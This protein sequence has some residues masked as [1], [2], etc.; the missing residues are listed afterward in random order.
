M[1]F[2]ATSSFATSAASMLI[3]VAS[4]RN[5]NQRRQIYFALIPL[6]FSIH[7]FIEGILWLSLTEDYSMQFTR[8]S[9]YL[10]TLI[11]LI[12]WPVWIPL[13]IL[14]MEENQIRQKWL[15]MNLYLGILMSTFLLIQT[16]LNKISAEIIENHIQYNFYFSYDWIEKW[17]V[18]YLIP[19]VLSHFYSTNRYVHMLGILVLG[20]FILTKLFYP[21][22]VF[23]VWCFFAALISGFVLFITSSW[24]PKTILT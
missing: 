11:G 5:V 6:W 12:F 1:C 20:S 17:S 13:S 3:G 18:L 2:S 22:Y 9:T 10:F 24:K 4:I 7:Q 23:S 14:M 16:V 15:R 8:V 21:N 19:T